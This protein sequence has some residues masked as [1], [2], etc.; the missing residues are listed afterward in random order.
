MPLPN[1]GD[2]IIL[3]TT[4]WKEKYDPGL[5]DYI[6]GNVKRVEVSPAHRD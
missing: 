5:R 3:D 6:K 1:H 2:G 4:G